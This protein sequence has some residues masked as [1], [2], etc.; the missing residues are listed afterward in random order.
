MW[1]RPV[2]PRP[3]TGVLPPHRPAEK[4]VRTHPRG[5]VRTLPGPPDGR[6]ARSEGSRS[7]TSSS[8]AWHRGSRPPPQ[9]S[10]VRERVG[11]HEDQRTDEALRRI[12]SGL[13]HHGHHGAHLPRQRGEAGRERRAPDAEPRAGGEA[14]RRGL[15][16]GRSR[17]LAAGVRRDRA[18]PLPGTLRRSRAHGA[19]F[20]GEPGAADRREL[21]A[22]GDHRRPRAAGPRPAG[23]AGY[24]HRIARTGHRDLGGRGV[25]DRRRRHHDRDPG[26]RCRAPGDP[27]CA[28]RWARSGAIEDGPRQRHRRGRDGC[29][30]GAPV[31]RR[32]YALQG[33][34]QRRLRGRQGDEE[35]RRRRPLRGDPSH[36]VG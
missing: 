28:E 1:A 23:R 20:G 15:G 22:P 5:V 34:L 10:A 29:G 35:D 26:H 9:H 4:G 31:H 32:L 11:V 19:R 6:Y 16:I 8:L 30:G 18:S 14:A 33:D 12:R 21:R 2:Y 3:A 25:H 24:G 13:R 36:V 7:L 17:D 27:G